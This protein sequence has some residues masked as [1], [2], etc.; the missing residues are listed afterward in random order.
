VA[1]NHPPVL[2]TI[3]EQCDDHDFVV[4]DLERIEE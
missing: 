1:Q 2:L 4:L 3:D